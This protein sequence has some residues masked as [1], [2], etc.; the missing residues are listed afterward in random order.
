MSRRK[1]KPE[2]NVL[3]G[4]ALISSSAIVRLLQSEMELFAFIIFRC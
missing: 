2:D 1:T 3:S 4:V